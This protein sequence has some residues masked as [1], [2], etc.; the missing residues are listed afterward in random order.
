SWTRMKMIC[1]SPPFSSPL[2]RPPWAATG[3]RR[4]RLRRTPGTIPPCLWGRGRR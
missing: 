3:N 1:P 2:H 4:L